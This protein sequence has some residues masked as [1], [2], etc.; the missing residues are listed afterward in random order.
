LSRTPLFNRKVAASGNGL[1]FCL[2]L[3]LQVGDLADQRLLY[4]IL[5]TDLVAALLV[6]GAAD[7]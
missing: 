3:P 7:E 1:L 2:P 6:S 5:A 4:S